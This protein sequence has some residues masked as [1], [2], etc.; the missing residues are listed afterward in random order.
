MNFRML[1][2]IIVLPGT[3]L[4]FAPG[5]ALWIGAGTEWDAD[6]TPD[7]L[8]PILLALPFAV[9]GLIMMIWS[10]RM[11]KIHG[12]DGTPAP[13]DPIPNFVANGPYLYVRNPML[14]GVILFQGAEA[15][16]LQSWPVFIWMLIFIVANMIY[17]PLS[18]EPGLEKRFGE[19]YLRYKEN[20]PRWIP[21]LSA[22]KPPSD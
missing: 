7:T 13:W 21:R 10:V 8:Q 5:L 17:F 3:A 2:A 15:A 4:V 14:I 22:W 20:V 6:F 18:E 11:Y 19:T 12:G 1:K 9:V 16:Y